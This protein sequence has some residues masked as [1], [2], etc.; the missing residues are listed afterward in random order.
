MNRRA[1]VEAVVQV[2]DTETWYVRAGRGPAV[3][4]LDG[5]A[6][7]SSGSRVFAVLSGRGRVVCPR[8]P[9]GGLSA[10]WL[11]GLVDGL[12]LSRPVVVLGG[13]WEAWDEEALGALRECGE[14]L[15]PVF[16]TGPGDQ[17]VEALRSLLGETEE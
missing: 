13:G 9:D 6:E 11:A 17:D 5:T 16:V 8:L 4:L 7:P 14:A 2:G 12:G 1:P 3:I 15:G 10:R